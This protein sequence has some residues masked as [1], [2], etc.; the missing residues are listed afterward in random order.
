MHDNGRR[1]RV[2]QFLLDTEFYRKLH[3]THSVHEVFLRTVSFVA[4]ES[5][6]DGGTIST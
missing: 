3:F 6:R 2:V 4:R 1:A 5:C